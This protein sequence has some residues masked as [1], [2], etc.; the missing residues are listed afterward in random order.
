MIVTISPGT[1]QSPNDKN[2]PPLA[3]RGGKLIFNLNAKRLQADGSFTI[4]QQ[5]IL[6][7]SF[8]LPKF[9]LDKPLIPK[10]RLLGK[11]N[12]QINSLDFLKNLSKDV[13]NPQGKINAIL[14]ADGTVK[15]PN[16]QGTI[17]LT[18]GA[19]LLPKL[20]I[21][22]NPI[23][24]S[25]RTQNKKWQAEGFLAESGHRLFLK[26]EGEFSP[27]LTG[28]LKAEGNSFPLIKTAEYNVDA[29]LQL[30][31]NFNPQAWEI[32]G[33]I[34]VPQAKLQPFSFNST[35][36]LT[37]DAIFVKDTPETKTPRNLSADVEVI[38]GKDVVLDVKG[39]QGYLDG[40]IHVK[41]IPMGEPFAV[42][43]L[44]I[45]DGKYQAYGQKLSIEEGE[46]SFSGGPIN[47]PG[48]RIRAIRTFTNTTANFAGSNQLFDFNPKNIQPLDF[49]DKT[50][51]GIEI[52]GR[53][54]STKIKLFS[55]PS[56]LSEADIL[57]MLILGKPA[58]QASTS[59]G[60]LLLTALSSMNLDS[61]TKGTQIIDQLK[62]TLGLDFN[63]ENTSEYNQ[64]T[65]QM[66]DGTAFVVGKS[67][68]NRLY[69]SYNIGLLQ[70]DVNV[71]T[72]K[73]L[74]NQFFSLQVTTS[75]S[76]S[77]VDLIYTHSKG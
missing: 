74:L 2:L 63:V 68:T 33:S 40:S 59:G 62:Q 42:G 72:L 49:G 25:V 27:I 32:Q 35:V 23:E 3:F 20:N 17:S 12:L 22:L 9:K 18:N 61:G 52:S 13:E 39:L 5:K 70:E 34:T 67:L 15:N 1:Y 75:D 71:L 44:Y 36:N 58:S 50:T 56:S 65:N 6:K 21:H 26:G 45:R 19:L 14:K 10:Q 57:S 8:N 41:Q 24:F 53:L 73:Y 37:E 77:G 31:L 66:T 60:Q 46:F 48:V 28:S 30:A 7:A 64:K 55:I 69:L 54:N 43:E 47:N 38:M 16:L 76:G 51:V 4:D 29:S 11:I